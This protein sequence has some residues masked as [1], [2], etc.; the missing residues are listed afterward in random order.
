MPVFISTHHHS[1]LELLLLVPT[2][3]C[4][5]LDDFLPE[6]S[7]VQLGGHV[8]IADKHAHKNHCNFS[9]WKITVIVRPCIMKGG[10]WGFESLF[11]LMHN[12]GLPDCLPASLEL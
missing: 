9:L 2:N 5:H 7:L 3:S 6:N 11:V 10:I 4:A 8:S 12:S 1:S